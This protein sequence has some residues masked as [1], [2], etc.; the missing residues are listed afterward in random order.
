MLHAGYFLTEFSL[1]GLGNLMTNK[2]RFGVRM[3]AFGQTGEVLIADR[4]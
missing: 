4:T 3:L 2:L 1:I